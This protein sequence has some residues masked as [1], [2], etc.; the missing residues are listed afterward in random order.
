MAKKAKKT[1]ARRAVPA[2]PK[3]N[4]V[5]QIIA[6]ITQRDFAS[7]LKRCNAT[8]KVMGEGRSS[9][10]GMIADAVEDKH[11]HKGAFG[12]FRRLDKM[13]DQKRSEFLHHFDY[14]R[15]MSNWDD[16]L[17]LFRTKAAEETVEDEESDTQT[18][19]EDGRPSGRANGHSRE[20]AP[21]SI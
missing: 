18:D 16:Q 1:A 6:V 19:L 7:L 4:P 21:P 13:S 12:V 5:A 8:E 14:Y 17:D 9:L 11:L 2:E 15:G 10:G 20:E 3:V